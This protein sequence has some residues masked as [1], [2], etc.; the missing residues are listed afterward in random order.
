M[1]GFGVALEHARSGPS[2]QCRLKPLRNRLEFALRSVAEPNVSDDSN[3]LEHVTSLFVRGWSG[4]E[5]VA[6]LDLEGICISSGSA[7]AAGTTEVSPV[8]AAMFGIDR[9]RSTIR[10]SLGET[11]T[12]SEI[13]RAIDAFHKVLARI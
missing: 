7:C 6:A 3:R 12:E 13:Q 4:A 9:A 10:V 2:E 1:A 8:I 11:T 5:L